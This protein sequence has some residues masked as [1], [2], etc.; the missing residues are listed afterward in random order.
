MKCFYICNWFLIF[1]QFVFIYML[2]F[3]EG[4]YNYFRLHK[5]S[6]TKIQKSTKGMKNYWWYQR[7]HEEFGFDAQY[8][9]N[10]VYTVVSLTILILHLLFGWSKIMSIPIAILISLSLI[11]YVPMNY[12]AIIQQNLHEHG[13]RFVFFKRRS[14]GT[15]G[16]DSIFIDLCR[17]LFPII[18][19]CIEMAALKGTFL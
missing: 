1:F 18:M 16:Y 8:Y 6:N 11:V 10:K 4:M 2:T 17:I 14:H 13:K 9:I 19:I 5:I 12:F 15:K 7:L 3:R